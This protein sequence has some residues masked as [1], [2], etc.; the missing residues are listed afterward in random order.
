MYLTARTTY[1]ATT[2]DE[3]T[4]QALIGSSIPGTVKR[5][6]AEPYEY[7]IKGSGEVVTLS[8]RFEYMPE[9]TP[10]TQPQPIQEEVFDFGGEGEN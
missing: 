10:K 4:V 7:T 6:A 5:V 2:F 3:A 8:H 9:D 1:V